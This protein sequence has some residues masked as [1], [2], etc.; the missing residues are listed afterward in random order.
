M[1]KQMIEPYVSDKQCR[2]CKKAK[3]VTEFN[4]D[5]SRPD[6][7]ARICRDCSKAAFRASYRRCK[8]RGRKVT[9]VDQ[10]KTAWLL[11]ADPRDF[12]QQLLAATQQRWRYEVEPAA[13]LTWI[14]GAAA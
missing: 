14:I 9:L 5:K 3:P 12:G 4:R 1:A 6:G 10:S 7:Y 2:D 13:N 8:A 11:P